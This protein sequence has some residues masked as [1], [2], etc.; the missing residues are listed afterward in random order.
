MKR[1]RVRGVARKAITCALAGSLAFSSFGVPG[2]AF[3]KTTEQLQQEYASAMAELSALEDALAQAQADLGKTNYELGE[4]KTSIADLQKKISNIEADL[5]VARDHLGDVIADSYKQGGDVSL[6]DLVLSSNS[7]DELVSRIYYANK[8]AETKREAI[9]QV[10]DLQTNLESSKSSLE[11]QERQQEELL[12]SQVVQMAAMQESANAQANYVGQLSSEITA[13]MEEERRQATIASLQAAREVLGDERVNEAAPAAKQG[14][15]NPAPAANAVPAGKT[16]VNEEP[17]ADAKPAAGDVAEPKQEQ[18]AGN[19]IEGQTPEEAPD[20]QQGGA[21]P[22]ELGQVPEPT[23]QPQPEPEPEPELEYAP[24]PELQST[25]APAP[26]PEPEYASE[27]KSESKPAVT[28][29]DY[30]YDEDEEEEEE[31]TTTTTTTTTKSSSGYSV[32]AASAAVNAAIA[33]V[34]I[35]YGHDNDGSNWD[36]NGLTNYAWSVAGVD[37]PLPSGTYSYGQFQWLKN[38]GNWVTS[39]SDLQA[40]DLV[41]FSHDGGSTCYHVAMY[42]GDGQIVHAVGYGSGVQIT[43]LDYVSGFCGGGSPA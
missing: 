35:A 14:A 13:A 28:Y 11:D 38:S 8:T 3:A 26:E 10:T 15:E 20:G 17:A 39:A 43:S 18:P 7:V 4:T 24:E 2:V 42:I 5:V 23:P 30:S 9:Q 6:I 1:Y 41:F 34:G 29:D 32:S 19:G 12:A 22:A 36:C 27:P 25:N 33:Q 16:A 21:A 37:I 31:E 40:G